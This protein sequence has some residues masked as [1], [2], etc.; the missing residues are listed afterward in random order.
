[1]IHAAT[2]ETGKNDVVLVWNTSDLSIDTKIQTSK[3]F[4]GGGVLNLSFSPSG[5]LLAVLGDKEVDSILG[6]YDWKTGELVASGKGHAGHGL[7]L[8]F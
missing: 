5:K 4:P 8:F 1:M 2:G 7:L 3:L 6:I